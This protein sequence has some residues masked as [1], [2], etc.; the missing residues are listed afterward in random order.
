MPEL[1]FFPPAVSTVAGWVDLLLLVLLGLSSI[2]TLIVL[3]LIFFW[4]IRYRRGRRV[5]RSNPPLTNVKIEMGWMG[6]LLFLGLGTFIGAAIVY[7]QIMRPPPDALDVY[8]V[9]QQWMWKV[10]HPEGPREINELHVP[11]GRP[12]RLTMISQDVIHSFFVPAFR[13]KFDVLPGRYTTMWF[14]ATEPGEYHIFCAEYCGTN[15]SRM[16]GQVVVMTP[17]EYERWL[18]EGGQAGEPGLPLAQ[19][20]EQLFTQLGCS[21]CHAA[22]S[23]ERAPTLA[24]LFGQQ[25]PLD[26]GSTVLADEAYIRE[27]ILFPNERVVAGYQPIMPTY[28]GRID[29]EQ[30]LQLVEYIRSLGDG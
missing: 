3:F 4:G 6:G 15:H 1:P 24:G 16:R 30:L 22:E 5:D 7:F 11:A 2:F 9:G 17:A 28:E 29:E 27:S 25:V 18:S 13:L 14:E 19:A 8:V 26:D 20:G 10:Q 23:N 21:G 12:V